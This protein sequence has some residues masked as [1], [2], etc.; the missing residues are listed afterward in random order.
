MAPFP[1]LSGRLI[2]DQQALRKLTLNISM[3]VNN[4]HHLAITDWKQSASMWMTEN[5]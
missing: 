1:F 3:K 5:F 4:G 2:V